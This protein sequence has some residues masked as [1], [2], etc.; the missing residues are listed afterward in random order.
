MKRKFQKDE[1]ETR[2]TESIGRN[3]ALGLTRLIRLKSLKLVEKKR[4]TEKMNA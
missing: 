1:R 2:V 3:N 4:K